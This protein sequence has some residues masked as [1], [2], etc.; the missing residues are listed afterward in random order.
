MR[1][2]NHLFNSLRNC[3]PFQLGGSEFSNDY[4]RVGSQAGTYCQLPGKGPH[5][6]AFEKSYCR[7]ALPERMSDPIEPSDA[8]A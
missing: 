8:L 3:P 7:T 5:S 1:D 6:S 4:I 2:L